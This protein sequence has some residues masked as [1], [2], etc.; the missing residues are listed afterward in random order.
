MKDKINTSTVARM[1]AGDVI[2]DTKTTGFAAR[3]LP[4][5]RV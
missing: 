5:R 3:K 4:G 1:E 2:A